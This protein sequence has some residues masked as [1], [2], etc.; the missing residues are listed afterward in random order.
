MS[1]VEI[2]VRLEEAAAALGA[3]PWLLAMVA[4]LA[5]LDGLFPPVPSETVLVTAAVLSMSGGGVHVV[6]IVPAA[7]VGAFAGDTL[8]YVLGRQLPVHRIPGLRGERGRAAVDTASGTLRRRGVP[9]VVAGRFVPVG[10]VAINVG[11]GALGLPLRRY[12][13]AAATAA[14]LWASVTAALG[15]GAY[16]IV[17]GHPLVSVAIGVAAG[18]LIGFGL[19]AVLQR[20]QRRRGRGGP[21]MEDGGRPDGVRPGP[22]SGRDSREVAPH[23]PDGVRSVRAGASSDAAADPPAE[24]PGETCRTPGSSDIR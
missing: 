2:F 22:A 16:A 8:T 19:D 4:G 14:T 12:L 5:M 20:V 10:R 18:V 15:A 13:P 3:S 11:A 9:M 23:R 7:A 1:C 24:R 17:G 21:P 6:L